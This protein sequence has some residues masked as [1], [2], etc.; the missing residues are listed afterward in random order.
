MYR[1][2]NKLLENRY[3]PA[4]VILV[5]DLFIVVTSFFLCYSLRWSLSTELLNTKKVFMQL[6]PLLTVYII[7]FSVFRPSAGILRHTTTHDIELILKSVL[8]S[9]IL[10]F[11]I[12]ITGRF[13]IQT[14]LL[15][16]PITVLLIHSLVAASLLISCRIA[17]KY[18]YH[19]LT[20]TRKETVRIMIYG[21]GNLGQATMLAMERSNSPFYEIAGFIDANKSLCG[22]RKS[23]V[24]IYSPAEAVEK[25][26]QENIKF[27]VIAIND[28]NIV[29]DA[30]EGLFNYCL[31]NKIELR[32]VPPVREWIDGSFDAKRITKI[33]I[34]DLLGRDEIKLDIT[35]IQNGL[36]GKTIMV[37]GAAGS[38]GSEIARQ[39]LS[40]KTGKIV[41]VDQAESALYDL[42][43]EIHA[44]YNG[45][46][47]F[48]PVI[49]DISNKERLWKIFLKYRPEIVFNAAAYKHVPLMEDNVC[50]A[51]RVNIGGT[52][53][54]AD[55]C[56]EF[57]V[58]KFV[59]VSSDKAV[60]PKSVMG[61][62][63][64]VCELYVQSLATGYNGHTQFITTRF[65]NVLGSN[66]SVV[67]LFTRQI[68]AGGPVTITHFDMIRYFMTIPEACQLVL[69]AGFMGKG[70]EIFLFDMGK[71]V[72]IYDLAVKMISLAGL[73]PGKDIK[74]IET[75]LRPGEKLFEEMLAVKEKNLPTHNP[76][77]LIANMR[78]TD[79]LVVK[80]Q[81]E[82]LIASAMEET[83]AELV[84]RIR[85]LVPEFEPQ[86]PKFKWHADNTDQADLHRSD[87]RTSV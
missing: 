19:Y 58:R 22:K 39:L 55:M 74:I 9:T 24:P 49:A 43:M 65:G 83:E 77:I 76:K 44:K 56:S 81:V 48:E 16:F 86:N 27:V 37:T 21:A 79:P 30:G 18:A 41:L 40:F 10:L 13:L 3:L 5:T 8:M 52:K 62:S 63:K 26:S 42:Q 68:E 28:A 75:G 69:E 64:R 4:W 14:D 11:A 60:N 80:K 15:N 53:L 20:T 29:K 45:S 32:K 33:S 73:E 61:A 6:L 34:D 71:P 2:V 47:D 50:E 31:E 51:V 36:E 7:S 57:G 35:G 87:Q 23:G 70:G 59:M 82:D 67:P 66:G 38:I 46:R 85:H 1:K 54:L 78:K 72:K 12:T 17:I 84:G 25:I